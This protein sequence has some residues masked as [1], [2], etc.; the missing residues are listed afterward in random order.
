MRVLRNIFGFKH[1]EV[2]CYGQNFTACPPSSS[3]LQSQYLPRHAA[4][5]CSTSDWAP[6][7]AHCSKTRRHSLTL[8]FVNAGVTAWEI[9]GKMNLHRRPTPLAS[10][11]LG[12]L[13]VELCL[14]ITSYRNGWPEETYHGCWHAPQ[15]MKT[16]WIEIGRCLC[17]RSCQHS[18]ALG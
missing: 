17:Y 12:I 1:F 2:T 18:S 8:G 3:G 16:A 6:T 9:S 15:N 7:T 5:P 14:R 10:S 13:R 4:T 11:F